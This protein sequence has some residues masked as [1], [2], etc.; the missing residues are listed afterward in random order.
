MSLIARW[1]GA[2]LVFLRSNRDDELHWRSSRQNDVAALRRAKALAEQAL[3]ADL[4]K[5]SQR[6]SHELA[7]NKARYD[8]ELAMVKTQCQQ[9]LKDYQQYLQSLDRLKDSL[10]VSYAHLPDALAFTIHHH[11]KQLLNRMWDSQDAQ[12]KLKIEM[13]LLQFMTAVHEDSQAAL[14]GES[15]EN[16]PQRALACIDATLDG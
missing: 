11:A 12:E 2:A 10:R 4:K 8:T 7:L 9:D 13:Q 6:L 15:P 5:Q 14:S 1:L 3:I 16:L